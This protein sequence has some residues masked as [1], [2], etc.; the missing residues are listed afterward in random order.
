MGIS[1]TQASR[2]FPNS[3]RKNLVPILF[4]TH[5][6]TNPTFSIRQP[7]SFFRPFSVAGTTD[8]F[9][10]YIKIRPDSTTDD[11]ELDP[12]ISA[13]GETHDATIASY[14]EYARACS[15]LRDT[16]N[17]PAVDIWSAACFMVEIS[18]DTPA[19]PAIFRD[20]G[21]S[22]ITFRTVCQRMVISASQIEDVLLQCQMFLRRVHQSSI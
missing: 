7:L 14:T 4:R 2:T 15:L 22:R 11:F 19:F 17:G 5:G 13:F 10:I 12:G 8:P 9:A 6:P 20:R 21:Q 3:Y 1:W 18:R 16:N